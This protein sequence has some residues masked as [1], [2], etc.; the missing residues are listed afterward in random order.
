MM[1]RV[2][3][4]DDVT[5]LRNSLLFMLKEDPELEVV[6]MASNGE[7]A[8]EKCVELVPDVILMDLKM[9]VCDGVEATKRIREKFS[10]VKILILT[11]FKEEENVM[12][13]LKNGA[14]GYI[15]KD[16]EP[17]ELIAAIKNAY[18]G[19]ISIHQD[20]FKPFAGNIPEKQSDMEPEI[21]VHDVLTQREKDIVRLMVEGK[22][23]KEISKELYMSEGAIRNLISEL[24]RRLDL[25]DRIQLAVYAIKNDIL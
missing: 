18:K 15:L 20:V 6:G 21:K 10:V 9:P 24:L 13:A 8:L 7:E 23:Y 11:T 16:I 1:I 3:I 12:T 14:N 2:L 5:I 22:S 19:I 17:R 4:V 25:K